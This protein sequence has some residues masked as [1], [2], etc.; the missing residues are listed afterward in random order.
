MLKKNGK[1][2][3]FSLSGSK[4]TLKLGQFWGNIPEALVDLLGQAGTQVVLFGN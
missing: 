3:M 4:K 1:I 2:P